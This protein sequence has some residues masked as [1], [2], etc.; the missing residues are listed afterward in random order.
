MKIGDARG[1]AAVALPD[2]LTIRGGV[3]GVIELDARCHCGTITH[4]AVK[5][6][7]LTGWIVNR[8]LAQDYFPTFTDD[9]R[10]ALISG[11]CAKCWDQLLR[12]D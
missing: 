4:L 1:S 7:D 2:H 6:A 10:E 11:T 3:A 8:G 12:E 9:Q 5:H